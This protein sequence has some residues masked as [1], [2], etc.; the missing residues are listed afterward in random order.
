MLHSMLCQALLDMGPSFAALMMASPVAQ[1]AVQSSVLLK[2][3]AWTVC[4]TA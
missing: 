2:Q 1:L 3:R 4:V